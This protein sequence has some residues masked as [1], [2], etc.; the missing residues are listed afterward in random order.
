MVLRLISSCC[1][2][3][4]LLLSL[5]WLAP[6]PVRLLPLALACLRLFHNLWASTLSGLMHA[7]LHPMCAT[8]NV[9]QSK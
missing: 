6:S 7:I 1:T 9:S 8:F 5:L 4:I 3:F 2:P